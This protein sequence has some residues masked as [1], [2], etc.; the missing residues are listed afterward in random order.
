[1]RIPLLIFQGETTTATVD[2]ESP[3]ECLPVFCG[4]LFTYE[5]GDH[6]P[7]ICLLSLRFKELRMS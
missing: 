1:M 2:H 7:N 6:S 4:R 5:R 3:C